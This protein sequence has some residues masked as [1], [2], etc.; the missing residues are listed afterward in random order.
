MKGVPC[1][2]TPRLHSPPERLTR[3]P[4]IRWFQAYCAVLCAA[5]VAVVAFVVKHTPDRPALP[6]DWMW[7]VWTHLLQFLPASLAVASLAPF[8]LPRRP[9]VWVYDMVIIC[10]GMPTGWLLPFSVPL[11]VFWLKPEVKAWFD[12]D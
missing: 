10:V 9:W 11:L 12:Q 6:G 7:T 8:V 5:C 4:V 1:P 2:I 3:P